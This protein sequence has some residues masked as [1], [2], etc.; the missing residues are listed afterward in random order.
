MKIL[1]IILSLIIVSNSKSVHQDSPLKIDKNNNII[2]LPP[3]F[4]VSKFD[5]DKSYLRINDK[6]V[7]LPRCLNYYFSIHKKPNLKLSASWYHS[8]EIMPYYLNFD[9]SQ[10]NV[11][12]G[13]SILIDLESLELIEVQLSIKQGNSTFSHSLKID[14][15]CIQEYKKRIN[16]AVD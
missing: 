11:D 8:K 14:D 15:S 16:C 13:Y 7:V 1:F 9:I 3:E 10:T 12:Y 6:E 5:L 2:G 4:G